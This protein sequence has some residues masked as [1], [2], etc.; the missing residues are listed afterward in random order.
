MSKPKNR[1]NRLG[2][3]LNQAPGLCPDQSRRSNQSHRSPLLLL[4]IL[5]WSALLGIGLAQVTSA[6]Q[7][8][9]QQLVDSA[10]PRESLTVAQVGQL[11][12]PTNP[13]DTV[14]TVTESYRQGQQYYLEGCATCHV[15]LP[16]AV[17]PSQTWAGL[18]PDPQH[19]GA[20]ITPITEPLLQIAWNYIS[21]YSRPIKE[22]ERVPYRLQQSRFFK[23]LHPKVAFTE[24]I[25]VNS[26][27]ACHPA[28]AQF[29]Y[30]RLSAEWEG[31]S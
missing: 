2:L 7:L 30:R 1:A 20:Q 19:Y 11:E 25:T 18:L 14:D 8:S 28:A 15:G 26:C 29:N 3:R 16:P 31:A 5:L 9:N 27:L 17:M 10:A 24:P 22:G 13:T 21:T 23:A 6:N 4:L 12:S